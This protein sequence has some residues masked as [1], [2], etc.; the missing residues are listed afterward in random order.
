MRRA[1]NRALSSRENRQ[2]LSAGK[3]SGEGREDMHMPL[4]LIPVLLGGAALLTGGL[5]LKKGLDARE[6]FEKAE[7]ITD[8]ARRIYDDAARELELV[9][10]E[11]QGSL[12]R[13]GVEKAAVHASCLKPFVA[14]AQKIKHIAQDAFDF[15]AKISLEAELADIRR[16]SLEISDVLKGGVAALSSGALA[17]FGAFGAA[18][19]LATA[20]TGTA[21]SAL[22]G[23]AA[24]NA[25]LAWFGGGALAAGGLGMAG[26]TLVLGGVVAAPV[27]AVG[28][29]VLAARAEA[30]VNDA[31]SNREKA[32]GAAESMKAACV[33]A[34][35]IGESAGEMRD[36]LRELTPYCLEFNEKL[37]DVVAR[38]T[39]YRRISACPEDAHTVRT[40]FAL[41][42]TLSNLMRAPL[43]D[44]DGAVVRETRSLLRDN[45]DFLTQLARM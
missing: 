25:T 5:G 15:D 33:G 30:A 18:G 41:A 20:S 32:L 31:C 10:R 8:E 7:R 40:A 9:R 23:A 3:S 16:V 17:G 19:L 21:I 37:R 1:E 44:D 26:G 14:S 36:V 34:R 11:T 13:L 45:R 6:N 42:K 22:S 12:E 2:A 43:F 39:D 24:A 27:L 38:E 35:A 4:P 28:G 29:L